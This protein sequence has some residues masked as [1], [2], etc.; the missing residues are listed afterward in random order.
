[1]S[2]RSILLGLLMAALIAGT[3]F[4]NDTVIKGSVLVSTF[5]PVSVFGLVILFVMLVN[6]VLGRISKGWALSGREVAVAMAIALMGC[7]VPGFGFLQAFTNNLLMPHK[8]VAW[9]S[10]IMQGDMPVIQ[11]TDIKDQDWPVL[12]RT[13]RAAEDHPESPLN[14]VWTRFPGDL[15]EATKLSPTEQPTIELQ[16]RVVEALNGIISGGRDFARTP[17]LSQLDHPRYVRLLLA[18][19]LDDLS[20]EAINR[21]NR[22]LLETLFSGLITRR[23]PGPV[24]NTPPQMVVDANRNSGDVVEGFVRGLPEGGRTISPMEVPWY[25]W[26]RTLLFWTPLALTLFLV[27]IGLALVV[28]RQWSKHEQLPYPTMRFVNAMLPE[29]GE[30]TSRIFRQRLFWI[31]LLLVMGFH[32]NNYAASWWPKYLLTIPREFNFLPV[33]NTI[34][35]FRDSSSWGE[36]ERM[37]RPMI[38]FAFVGFAYFLASDVSLSVGIGP[39]FYVA[40]IGALATYGINIDGWY[41]FPG[42]RSGGYAGA[43][44]AFFLV[45]LYLGRQY[46]K[47]VLRRAMFLRSAEEVESQ[48]VWG[49]RLAF[50]GLIVFGAQMMA[51]GLEWQYTLLYGIGIV[52]TLVVM[53]RLVAEAGIFAVIPYFTSCAIIHGF[54]GDEAIGPY[55]VLIMGIVSTTLLINPTETMMPFAVS[56]FRLAEWKGVKSGPIA[57]WGAVALVISFVI[58]IPVTLYLQYQHGAII[59]RAAW[60]NCDDLPGYPFRAERWMRSALEAKGTLATSDALSGW[61]H[62]THAVPNMEFTIAFAVTF[63]LVFLLSGL[64]KRFAWWPLH[65]I[66]LLGLANYQ[67]MRISF[68]FL[69]GWLIKTVVVKYG[70]TRSYQKLMPFMMGLIAGDLLMGVVT[71]AVGAIYYF[72]TGRAPV[73]YRV[74]TVIWA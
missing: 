46:Y 21:L 35:V 14:A 37:A 72:V 47:A 19:N 44:I 53:S 6:P 24:E 18:R 34:G 48:A 49:A 57:R 54:L 42:G 50:V 9:T 43:Y 65:P 36:F 8:P 59:A 63:S 29:E 5:M 45:L 73:D 64:R 51:L 62:F 10:S 33:W 28:H 7:C 68:S 25:A 22:G 74:L 17:G 1:M 20:E 56:A 23:R 32:L 66:C 69:V 41:M 67:T 70:G 13:L 71:I 27:S 30:T 52:A 39:F 2:K 11:T 55:A 40:A 3:A 38:Q 4:F 15:Q 26:K 16:R 12:L 60:W 61:A 31:G 58:A